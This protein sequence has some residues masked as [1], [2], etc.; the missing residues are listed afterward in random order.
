MFVDVNVVAIGPVVPKVSR[1]FDRYW[2]SDASY[3]ASRLM[4]PIDPGQSAKIETR[5]ASAARNPNVHAYV[6]ALYHS[7][8]VDLLIQR[9][10]TFE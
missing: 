1:D 3:P 4:A 9:R 5:L 2:A 8:P 7:P 6:E 10:L